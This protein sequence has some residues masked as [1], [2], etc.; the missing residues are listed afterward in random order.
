MNW[1]DERYVRVYTRDTAEWLALRWEAKALFPLLLR[2]A[3]RSGVVAM[4]PGP[5][6]A[7]LVAGLTGLPIEIAESGLA[8]LLL[9]G[10]L[11]DTEAGYV[12]RNFIEAQETPASDAQRAREYRDRERARAL[13]AVTKRDE[14]PRLASQIVTE[15]H[16]G[17]VEIVTPN[18]AVLSVPSVPEE[19]TRA[20][21]GSWIQ[22]VWEHHRD[23]FGGKGNVVPV[24]TR[25]LIQARLD[26]GR[27]AEEL[28]DAIDGFKANTWRDARGLTRLDQIFAN[29]DMVRTGMGWKKR[30]PDEEQEARTKGRASEADRDW[31]KPI[32][33]D[34]NGEAV[35]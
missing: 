19:E 30:P 2:K 13:G 25:D 28:M 1:A 17:R 8:D 15:S 9:D 32:V 34:A 3:D 23:T 18:R 20:L 35:L 26:D 16:V 4:K 22:S 33:V 14:S 31:S 6:R 10:C 29:D 24:L 7:R 11:V 27:S 21:R 5:M 12:F